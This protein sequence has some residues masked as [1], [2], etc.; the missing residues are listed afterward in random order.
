MK[1]T[2]SSISWNKGLMK[3]NHLFHFKKV[4]ASYIK[5]CPFLHAGVCYIRASTN[6]CTH[7]DPLN[8]VHL[9][10]FIFYH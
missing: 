9:W 7:V 6:G 2:L 10:L 8:L 1:H 3:W 4:Q 5:F